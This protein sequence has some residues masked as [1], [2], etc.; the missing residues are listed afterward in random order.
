[1]KNIIFAACLMFMLIKA[2][3]GVDLCG[4]CSDWE[5]E[6]FAHTN[7]A[8][9]AGGSMVWL[10]G[11]NVPPLPDGMRVLG[12]RY[13]QVLGYPTLL[14]VYDGVCPPDALGRPRPFAVFEGM[15]KEMGL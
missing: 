10:S 5:S 4:W 7:I 2:D 9:G 6:G 11:P 14:T 12:S 8:A 1:M 3:P 15:E 13:D